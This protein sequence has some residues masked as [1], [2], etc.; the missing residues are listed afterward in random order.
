MNPKLFAIVISTFLLFSNIAFALPGIPHQFYGTVTVNGGAA[1]D[2]T[3]V[4]AR[5]NGVIVEST[6]TLDGKYGYE[7]PLFMVDDPDNARTGSTI[8]FFVEGVDS[9][10]TAIFVNGGTTRLDLSAT[11]SS[12]GTSGGGAPSGGGSSSSSG[13]STTT[14]ETTGTTQEEGCQEKWTCSG[15]GECVNGVQTRTCVDENDCGTN[16]R[17]PFSSQPCSPEENEE[18]G[19]I[20]GFFFLT[21]TDLMIAAVAGALIATI[22]ILFLKMRRPKSIVHVV[23]IQPTETDHSKGP[24][25]A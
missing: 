4:D 12:S 21:P 25:K 11:V 1:P 19:G 16:S 3:V 2:G 6:T 5:I 24:E 10:S 13:T 7:N 14:T 8:K 15:W 9:G 18:A 23:K 22:G 17:E 20:T